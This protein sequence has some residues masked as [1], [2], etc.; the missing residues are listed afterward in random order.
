MIELLTQLSSQA[1]GDTCWAWFDL[2]SERE[3]DWALAALTLLLDGDTDV[4]QLSSLR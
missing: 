3:E 4:C 2:F 1:L